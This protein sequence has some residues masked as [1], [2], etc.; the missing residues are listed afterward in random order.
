MSNIHELSDKGIKTI[1]Y[2]GIYILKVKM[3]T[4]KRHYLYSIYKR[5]VNLI[6]KGFKKNNEMLG[7]LSQF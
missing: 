4:K 5:Y 2:N 7:T 3:Y 6:I 1:A